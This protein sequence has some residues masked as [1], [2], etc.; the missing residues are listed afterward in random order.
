MG[1]FDEVENTLATLDDEVS[2]LLEEDELLSVVGKLSNERIEELIDVEAGRKI[3]VILQRRCGRRCTKYVKH[4]EIDLKSSDAS[5]I[6]MKLHLKIIRLVI[7]DNLIEQ[8]R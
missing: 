5:C 2:Q 8:F 6:K 7:N 4:S 1:S 3:R